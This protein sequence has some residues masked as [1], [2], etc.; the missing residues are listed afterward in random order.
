MLKLPANSTLSSTAHVLLSKG[1]NVLLHGRNPSKL[2]SVMS[3][4]QSL[5][6]SRRL[7]IV[8]ADFSKPTPEIISAIPN[9][10]REN[11]LRVT[12][13]FNNVASTDNFFNLFQN[14]TPEVI[15]R[16]VNVGVVVFTKLYREMM[17]LM[18]EERLGGRA[19]MVNIGSAAGEISTPYIAV[20]S[21]TKGYMQVGSLFHVPF[22]WSD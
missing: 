22:S 2:E 13:F 4:L 9:Y 16:I 18:S 17:P 11:N 3:S 7:A 14:L 12:L 10:I 20:Y 1:F 6:P 21:G 15:D 5:H 8:T 19:M